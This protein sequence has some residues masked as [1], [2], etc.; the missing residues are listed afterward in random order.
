MSPIFTFDGQYNE[1]LSEAGGEYRQGDEINLSDKRA[2]ELLDAGIK[3]TV[4]PS[5]LAALSRK[6]LNAKAARLGIENPGDLPNKDAVIAAINTAADPPS[7]PEADETGA[8][9]DTQED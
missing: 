3:L 5:D 2:Q 9:H 7:Q 8:G 1:T 4:K 6:D